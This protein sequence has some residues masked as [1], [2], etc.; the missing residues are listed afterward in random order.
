MPGPASAAVPVLPAT[1]S[2]ERRRACRCPSATTSFSIASSC[3][4]DAPARRSAAAS[5]RDRAPPADVVDEVRLHPDAVVRERA[6]RRPPSGSASPRCPGRSA[7]CRSSS[8]T[9]CSAAARCPGSR[10]GSRSRSACRSR[11]ARSSARAAAAPSCSRERDRADVRRARRGSARR[12]IVSVPRGSASW[13]DA[14]GDLD[15]VRQR[16]RRRSA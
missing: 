14:V 12:V 9:S 10:P 13:I 1:C 3:A 4:R 15:R 16:E 6:R 2:R 5:A 8:P 11:S 7:R